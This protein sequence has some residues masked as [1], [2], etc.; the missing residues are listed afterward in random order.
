MSFNKQSGFTLLEV[1]V[2][3]FV[4]SIGL[5][6]L[7]H[8]QVTTL[9]TTQSADFKTQASMLATDMLNRMKANQNAAY[10]GNYTIDIDEDPP[11]D[12]DVT[13]NTDLFQWRNLVANQLPAGFGSVAC[14]AFNPLNEF[15]CTITIT[16]TDIQTGTN[17]TQ[18][19]QR[20]TSTLTMDGA[21]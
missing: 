10:A 19:N 14:P 5:L 12:D 8:L 18:Y 1:M 13:S 3:V 6:G 21:V 4:L 7:A 2:A 20:A 9:K 16:W 15:V 17:G 11:A